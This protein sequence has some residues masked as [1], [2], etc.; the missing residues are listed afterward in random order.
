MNKY[1]LI[2]SQGAH[3][4]S[5]LIGISLLG[6]SASVLAVTPP[7]SGQVLDEMRQPS[8]PT[9][10]TTPLRIDT[11]IIQP[12]AEP[13]GATV[14]IN[15]IK[16]TG[17]SLF[18]DEQLQAVVKNEIGLE[19]DLA[20]LQQ[21]AHK[22]TQFYRD[23]DYP[24]SLAYLPPQTLSSGELQIAIVE[25]VYGEIRFIGS[26]S[27][28]AQLEPLLPHLNSGDP[29]KGN[30]LERA[31]SLTG[32]IPG[33]TIDPVL[34]PGQ[35]P[36]S[37]DL[38][39]SVSETDKYSGALGLDNHGNRYTGTLRT[40][41]SLSVN[42]LATLG[43]NLS[44][45]VM[46]TEEELWYGNIGYSLRIA[47]TG[48]RGYARYTQ[49]Y[50][51]LGE[52]FAD[53]GATGKARIGTLGI[54]YPLIRSQRTNLYAD[55]AYNYKLLQDKPSKLYA[56]NQKNSDT[57]VTSLRFD[58]RDS[59]MGGGLTWSD[60]SLTTG[61]LDLDRTLSLVDRET[62]QTEGSFSKLNL[63]LTRIQ[64]LT[65]QWSLYGH[66]SGQWTDDNLD[67]SEG[68]SLG[69]AN[70]VRAYPEGEAF[71]DRGWLGQLELRYQYKQLQPYLFYDVGAME[72]NTQPWE[73]GDNHRKIAGAGVGLRANMNA[74]QLNLVS[75]WRTEG[76][77]PQS[78]T[79]DN[80]PRIWASVQYRY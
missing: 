70:G 61:E 74:W 8:Q 36:G 5:L 44:L 65:P 1:G 40:H 68:M 45:A 3:S 75:A 23:Q 7:D 34:M 30:T 38:E 50:Y 16:F 63:D 9:L 73:S 42:Q 21:L 15:S 72:S 24:F 49:T 19:H 27:L 20:G 41:A 58:H 79:K 54:E 17:N 52:E 56:T 48:A 51:Q 66:I 46:L 80:R 14:A 39:I 29:I 78:D 33:I 11:Q 18:S 53:L 35:A 13:G 2:P 6:T 55:L 47:N 77:D 57:L 28:A 12:T 4:F 67:S 10:Q 69:G 62:A 31:I 59:F 37:G 26:D 76:G 60:F 32:D 71:G 64:Y 43:D 25:G 22:I